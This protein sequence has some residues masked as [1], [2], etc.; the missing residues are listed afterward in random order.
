MYMNGMGNYIIQD[1]PM[2][3]LTAGFAQGHLIYGVHCA[4]T[5]YRKT[6]ANAL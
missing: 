5:V 4:F 1:R 2:N 6:E 3:Y